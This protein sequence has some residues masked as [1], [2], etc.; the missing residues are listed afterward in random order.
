MASGLT[1]I[2]C[3][4]ARSGIE[5]WMARYNE[6]VF[7]ILVVD[8]DPA[9]VYLLRQSFRD[10][11]RTYQLDWV[12]DGEEALDFLHRR[13]AHTDATAPH[14]ILMDINMP[15]LNGL[16]AVQAIKADPV[17][18]VRP[19]IVLSTA[20]RP[21]EVHKIYQSHANAYVQKPADLR[22]FGE[23]LKAIEVF[24]VDFAL[25]PSTP[26][27]AP[28]GVSDKGLPIAS[29]TSEVSSQAMSR[30]ESDAGANASSGSLPCAEHQR[31][32]QDFAAAV[33]ELLTLHEQQFQ[34]IVQGDPDCN[35]FDLL[36]HMA[37]EKKQ[38]AK[39]AYLRHVESHG[40]SNIDAIA[41]ASG[42]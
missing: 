12:K 4:K 26:D 34:A 27:S 7:H 41:N 32:M 18:S 30:D 28:L 29:Q 9:F 38:E 24:W 8:D 36:I 17:H 20:A 31:L 3:E 1:V 42:T 19:V 33:K 16:Q 22:G 2:I 23:L 10:L 35:R 6:P 14:L 37:N 21:S 5:G 39:Y 11:S 15:R 40:C 25:L 13:N